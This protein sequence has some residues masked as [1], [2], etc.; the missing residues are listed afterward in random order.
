MLF[1]AAELKKPLNTCCYFIIV[2]CRG[3]AVLSIMS[4]SFCNIVVC[5]IS[6]RGSKR[7]ITLGAWGGPTLRIWQ[8]SWCHRHYTQR[9]TPIVFYS[10]LNNRLL[11]DWSDSRLMIKRNV[12][13]NK[14][15]REIICLV[16]AL[17]LSSE[18]WNLSK[19]LQFVNS[20]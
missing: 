12:F 9:K 17:F 5:I 18:D 11:I 4:S 20:F 19:T 3:C 14:L 7:N 8:S 13:L 2:L 10:F 6:C 15:Y 1:V 16:T